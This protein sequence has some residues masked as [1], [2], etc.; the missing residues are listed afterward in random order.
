[1]TLSTWLPEPQNNQ[2]IGLHGKE[3][4]RR[5]WKQQALN[6]RR[7]RQ[8]ANIDLVGEEW[9]VV[10]AAQR[11]ARF[12]LH[13]SEVELTSDNISDNSRGSY[14]SFYKF[15]V[16]LPW[17]REAVI[18]ELASTL[19]VY[20]LQSHD[21]LHSSVNNSIVTCLTVASSWSRRDSRFCRRHVTSSGQWMKHVIDTNGTINFHDFTDMCMLNHWLE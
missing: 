7:W 15:L 3:T 4:C 11:V 5:K 13:I 19:H 8:Q 14:T 16:V 17:Q 18:N 9:S 20:H 12:T 6:T 1:M 21:N 10:Y 2:R